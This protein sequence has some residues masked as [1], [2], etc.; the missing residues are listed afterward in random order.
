MLGFRNKEGTALAYGKSDN[1]YV[2]DGKHHEDGESKADPRYKYSPTHS[3]PAVCCVPN[4]GRNFTYF[5]EQMWMKK[6]NGIAAVMFGP[7]QLTTQIDGS[8]ISIEQITNYPMSDEVIFKFTMDVP[9]TFNFYIRKPN[10]S[11]GVVDESAFGGFENGY[12]V[13]SRKWKT[14]DTLTVEFNNEIKINTTNNDDVYTQKGPLVYAYEI[15]HREEA[16]KKYENGFSDYY[17]FP[18]SSGYEN[19][20]L[21]K[22]SNFQLKSEVNTNSFYNSE[23]YLEGQ[24]FDSSKNKNVNVQLVPMG[25]TVLRRVTFPNFIY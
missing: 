2:L 9:K 6:E 10:W 5:L 19:L 25:K 17:C 11:N 15:Q 1:C 23:W 3:E 18:T 20:M 8:N 16:I 4:Y 21:S 22:D 13:V 14:G 12:Y 7:S 24:L